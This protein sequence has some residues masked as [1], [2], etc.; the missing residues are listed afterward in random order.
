MRLKNITAHLFFVANYIVSYVSPK[1]SFSKLIL[2]SVRRAAA[3]VWCEHVY[4]SYIVVSIH[5]GSGYCDMCGL[6][7]ERESRESF[8]F[9]SLI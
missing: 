4:I 8:T 6:K 2:W 1:F 9:T 5:N 3:T 7:R